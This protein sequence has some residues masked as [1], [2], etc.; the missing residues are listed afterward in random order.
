MPV[1]VGGEVTQGQAI[2]LSGNTG[3]SSG[4]HQH[5]QVQA[6]LRRLGSVG[7]ST[8]SERTASSPRRVR[9]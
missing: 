4:P 3:Q 9:P 2:A 6:E 7:G 1:N 8:R 5:F